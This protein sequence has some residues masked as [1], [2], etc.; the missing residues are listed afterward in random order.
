[1]PHPEIERL[2]PTSSTQTK[3]AA[4]SACVATEVRN[5]M[6][7]DQAVAMCSQ[8]AADKTGVTNGA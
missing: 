6:P 8:L 5:G 1:M 4:V 3:G 7:Q 2:E